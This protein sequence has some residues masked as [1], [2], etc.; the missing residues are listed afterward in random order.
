MFEIDL[1][2]VVQA[3]LAASFLYYG[4]Q[5][6]EVVKKIELHDWRITQLESNKKVS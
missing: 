3:V 2:A 1:A 5:V 4:R 6:S